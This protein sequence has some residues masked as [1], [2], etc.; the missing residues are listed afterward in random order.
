M[1]DLSLIKIWELNKSSWYNGDVCAIPEELRD[2]LPI[3]QY[4]AENKRV[5]VRAPYPIGDYDRYM[6][7]SQ[8]SGQKIECA[9]CSGTG[10]TRSGSICPVCNGTGVPCGEIG[11]ITVDDSGV[12]NLRFDQVSMGIDADGKLYARIKFGDDGGIGR[13][14]NDE[15]VVKVDDQTIKIDE[16]GQL[17]SVR[18]QLYADRMSAEEYDPSE[19]LT[20]FTIDDSK[21]AKVTLHVSVDIRST[22]FETATDMTMFTLNV[23]GKTAKYCWDKTV[24]YTMLNFDAMIDTVVQPMPLV[25]SLIPENGDD[26]DDSDITVTANVMSC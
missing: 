23:A 24:P 26:F 9:A 19:P 13:N 25:L 11:A 12:I 10:K 18:S 7:V 6:A 21:I 22:A 15:I 16:H 20:L 17:Y 14:E 4:V 1:A 5:T 8:L 2:W 3:T